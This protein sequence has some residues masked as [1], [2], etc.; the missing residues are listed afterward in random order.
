MATHVPKWN[1]KKSSNATQA[2]GEL[3]SP[4]YT[5]LPHS[6]DIPLDACRPA[7]LKGQ[8]TNTQ[9]SPHKKPNLAAHIQNPLAALAII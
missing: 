3:T 7:S 6:Q 1:E 2:T 4:Y 5:G 8:P 9:S